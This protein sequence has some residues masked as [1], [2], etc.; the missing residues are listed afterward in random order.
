MAHMHPP[1]LP[2]AV[3][4][5]PAR[6]HDA[7]IFKLLATALDAEFHVFYRC[8]VANS[9][10]EPQKIP[11]FVILHP[12]HGLLGI[13]IADD[14]LPHAGTEARPL[15]YSPIRSAL[16]TLI[17]GLKEQGI[18]FYI[19]A[20]CCVLFPH[21]Q[22]AHY[23]AATPDMEYQP[24][25]ADDFATLQERITAMMPIA[26]GFSSTWRVP[27]AV[28][29]ISRLLRVNTPLV[30]RTATP[31][32]AVPVGLP[33]TTSQPLAT[34]A[35]ATESARIVYVVRAIDILLAFATLMAFIMLI[36]FLPDGALFRALDYMRSWSH[37]PG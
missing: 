17:F 5:D 4:A 23:A 36:S 10:S 26:T 15:P 13:A 33:Q 22:R 3:L 35:T 12:R 34:P 25:F 24:L 21:S 32:T 27:D 37:P 30:E 1:E 14:S 28:E 2:I 8:S 29:R 11:D 19:P 20:P 7:A 31:P 16:R 9:A 6:R 18:R